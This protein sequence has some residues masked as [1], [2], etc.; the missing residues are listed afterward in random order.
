MS[1]TKFETGSVRSSDAKDF[2]FTSLPPLGLLA[3]ARTAGEGA[4]K[5]GRFNYLRGMPLYDLLEHSFKH[6]LMFN[7]GDRSEPHLAHA[8]WGLLTAIQEDVM[9]PEA[10]VPHMLGPGCTVTP[11][12]IAYMEHEKPIL[13]EKRANADADA[14]NWNIF[15]LAEVQKLRGQR[16]AVNA[17]AAHI[18][19]TETLYESDR[20]KL[21]NRAGRKSNIM[22]D[23]I[24]ETIREAIRANPGDLTLVDVDDEGFAMLP[25]SNPTKARQ[26]MGP[27]GPFFAE[28]PQ[29]VRCVSATILGVTKNVPAHIFHK[30]IECAWDHRETPGYTA[31]LIVSQPGD[32]CRLMSPALVD[33]TVLVISDTVWDQAKELKIP[34]VMSPKAPRVDPSFGPG[35]TNEKVYGKPTRTEPV[36]G[37]PTPKAGE[38]WT[39][40]DDGTR[41]YFLI[42]ADHI[43]RDAANKAHPKRKRNL[44]ELYGEDF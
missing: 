9:R 29:K 1:D 23:V 25:G 20:D 5:Y 18:A 42:G 43:P 13:A 32:E 15:D 19:A 40:Y 16:D 39:E 33:D 31:I 41:A 35:S 3:L 24:G 28:P 11:A 44:T 10:H 2:S 22:A 26:F 36:C 8:A 38:T 14:Y 4:S 6:M 37:Q 17:T 12:M 7:A 21:T 27:D 30:G 34:I